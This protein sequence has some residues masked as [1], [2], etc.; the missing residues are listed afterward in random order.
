M[1]MSITID[2]NDAAPEIELC[3]EKCKFLKK[4]YCELFGK[5]LE[6]H[7]HSKIDD[8]DGKNIVYEET[9]AFYTWKRY[10]QC[11]KLFYSPLILKHMIKEGL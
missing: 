4:G 5:Q 6:E 9:S 2:I 1:E 8:F 7:S 11:I 10:E 3:G